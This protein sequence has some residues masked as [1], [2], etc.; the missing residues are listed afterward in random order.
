MAFS[1]QPGMQDPYEALVNASDD[2]GS[3]GLPM[4]PTTTPPLPSAVVPI[5]LP[6]PAPAPATTT[7]TCMPGPCS[8]E[9]PHFKGK[10]INKFL[11][12]FEL[13]A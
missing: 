10:K 5:T 9:A 1:V 7:V 13:Q 2:E 12:E 11:H 4:G 6:A 8:C 3:V